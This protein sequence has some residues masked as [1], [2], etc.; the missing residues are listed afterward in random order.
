MNITIFSISSNTFSYTEYVL[1]F[2]Y[3]NM[4]V[5]KT[6]AHLPPHRLIPWQLALLY[7]EV[8]VISLK[9]LYSVM[10][11]LSKFSTDL[12]S[13]NLDYLCRVGHLSL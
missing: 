5:P 9:C 1:A 2:I 11:K 4:P 10:R 3:Q 6:N 13:A 7:R 8:Q 12:W